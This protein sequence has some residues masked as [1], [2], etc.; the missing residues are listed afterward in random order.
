MGNR[1][2]IEP[3]A[4]VICDANSGI[5]H[6]GLRR[7]CPNCQCVAVHM[8][9]PLMLD[10][11]RVGAIS[12]VQCT[13]CRQRHHTITLNVPLGMSPE[14]FYR[15]IF[16]EGAIK[17]TAIRELPAVKPRQKRTAGIPQISLFE[18]EEA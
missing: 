12:E 2:H 9:G 6:N 8:N 4:A 7:V 10:M 3:A 14:R 18:T 11:W 15:D 13:K 16:P 1:L 5:I 17:P